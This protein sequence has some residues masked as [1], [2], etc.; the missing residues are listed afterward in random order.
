[1]VRY[2]WNFVSAAGQVEAVTHNHGTWCTFSLSAPPY[3]SG[4]NTV[5][6]QMAPPENH[7]G[8]HSHTHFKSVGDNGEFFVSTAG[9]VLAVEHHRGTC[10]LCTLSLPAPPYRSGKNT[11]KKKQM[12]TPKNTHEIVA[13]AS[14]LRRPS[15]GLIESGE[16]IL[17]VPVFTPHHGG[18]PGV[19]RAF[20][21]EFSL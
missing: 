7:N 6:K 1:M 20:R 18:T 12:T 16:V 9:Q 5:I 11:Q 4:K 3:R 10:S 19:P 14:D 2:F 15:D 13:P 8:T 21:G 17:R